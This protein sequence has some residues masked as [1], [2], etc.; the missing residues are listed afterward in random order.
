MT[1]LWREIEALMGRTVQPAMR[2][3]LEKQFGRDGLERILEALPSY[4]NGE[5]AHTA[6]VLFT[7]GNALGDETQIGEGNVGETELG[8]L[9]FLGIRGAGVVDR[10]RFYSDSDGDILRNE[11]VARPP[12]GGD[13]NGFKGLADNNS[14]F[15]VSDSGVAG[16]ESYTPGLNVQPKTVQAAGFVDDDLLYQMPELIQLMVEH[17]LQGTQLCPDFAIVGALATFA[18]VVGN[19]VRATAWGDQFFLNEYFLLVGESGNSFKSAITRRTK[20]TLNRLDPDLLAPNEGSGEGLVTVFADRPSMLWIKDEFSGLLGAIEKQDYMRKV[21]EML[22]ELW[23]YGPGPYE[24]RLMQKSYRA[25]NVALSLLGTIQPSA[26]GEELATNRNIDRGLVNRLLIICGEGRTDTW[27]LLD[28]AYGVSNEIDK[29]LRYCLSMKG[30]VV[31]DVEHLKS[32]AMIWR[33]QEIDVFGEYGH[34][35]AKRATPHALRIASLFECADRW[36]LSGTAVQAK[37]L[38]VA[39]RLLERWFIRSA[40]LL[41]ETHL[42]TDGE[43]VRKA[44]LDYLRQK[45]EG[46]TEGEISKFLHLGIRATRDHLETLHTRGSVLLDGDVF[47]VY[48]LS[49]ATQ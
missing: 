38:D 27:P 39:L 20:D 32:A 47:Q 26:A 7:I 33:G 46:G 31:I 6:N 3:S 10:G 14:L 28:D 35:V 48:R 17:R 2:K 44:I 5:K 1:T 42:K 4:L 30:E 8:A 29:R 21:R 37:W 34:A 41:A 36:P 13:G 45:P 12:V 18:A 19:K 24:R 23:D 40:A 25:N 49:E 11:S 43:A 9:G 16:L 22:L 15:S